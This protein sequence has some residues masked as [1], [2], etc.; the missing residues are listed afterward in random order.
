MADWNDPATWAQAYRMRGGRP[1]KQDSELAT[2]GGF[3]EILSYLD[4]RKYAVQLADDG[5][6]GLSSYRFRLQK[7]DASGFSPAAETL[8][9]GCG[10]GWLVEVIVDVGSNAVWGTDTGTL[11][12]AGLTDPNIAVR[13]DIQALILNIDFTSPNA[14]QL[15]KA[16]GA[17][18]NKGEFRNIVTEHLLE[19]W[20]IGDIS[21]ALDACDN[22]RAA[23][24]SQ[25]YHL[26][27]PAMPGQDTDIVV[28]QL[29]IDEWATL[30]PEHYWIDISSGDIRGGA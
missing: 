28:N 23:G 30:R 3:G 15:F 10:F 9:V 21:T 4:G 25:V 13:S 12:Q 20:P 29:T 18:T 5:S 19:D 24:Q 22:L 2:G 16:A 27:V 1:N 17:G 6:P 26:V 7:L 11:I 8:I 14:K